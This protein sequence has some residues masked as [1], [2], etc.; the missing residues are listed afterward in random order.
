[1]IAILTHMPKLVVVIPTYNEKENTKRI[2]VKLRRTF[3]KLKKWNPQILIVDGNSPDGTSIVVKTLSQR[4]KNVHLLLEPKKRGLGAA[5]LAGMKH[6]FGKLKADV[7]V[8][9]DADLS[10]DPAYL[11]KLLNQIESGCDFVVG[12]RY[13]KGGSIPKNWPPHRKFLSIFGNLATQLLLESSA[14]NDWTTGYRAFKKEVFQK[15]VPVME[16]DAAFKGYTFNISF[17]HHTIEAGF[18]AGQVP[19]NFIDRTLGDSKL[20]MEYLFYTPIFLIKT[21]LKKFLSV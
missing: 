15:V 5:Y 6:A 2:I 8:T 3:L 4:Y 18:K 13:I 14:I 10:H 1:M 16:K 12:S 17:A 19:I 21:R 11:P 20:G 9:M 7:A